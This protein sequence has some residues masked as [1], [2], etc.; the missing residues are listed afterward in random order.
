MMITNLTPGPYIQVHGHGGSTPWINIST[1]SAGQVRYNPSGTSLEVYDGNN[2]NKLGGGQYTIGLTFE[3][4]KVIR[5][6]EE[7]MKEDLELRARMKDHPGLQE[8][9]ERLEIMKALTLEEAKK[10]A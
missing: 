1:L 9:Y 4:E 10:N 6:A 2:W 3:A 7:K 5:W 8:A